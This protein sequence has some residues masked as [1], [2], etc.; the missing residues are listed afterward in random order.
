[1]EM[2]TTNYIISISSNNVEPEWSNGSTGLLDEKWKPIQW[3][4]HCNTQYMHVETHA[5]SEGSIRVA[6]HR[7]YDIQY[8]RYA[9]SEDSVVD[10]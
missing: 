5:E 6:Q 1:M 7:I 9:K 4:E 2:C 3:R 8:T 10:V